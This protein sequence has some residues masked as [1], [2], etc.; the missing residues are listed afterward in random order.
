[1]FIEC[2]NPEHRIDARTGNIVCG[3]PECLVAASHALPD[4]MDRLPPTPPEWILSSPGRLDHS[5]VEAL[6]VLGDFGLVPQIV[7]PDIVDADVDYVPW[8]PI[9]HRAG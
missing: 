7:A 6:A 1:M 3:D 8:S 2:T 5:E 4:P 9:M